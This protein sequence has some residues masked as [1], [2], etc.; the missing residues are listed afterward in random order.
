MAHAQW[1]EP[2]LSLVVRSAG[3]PLQ[4]VAPIQAIARRLDPEIPVA[5]VRSMEDA[6][7]QSM[8]SE[9]LRT[10]IFTGFASLALLLAAVGI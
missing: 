7:G 6:L 10:A 5:E 3:D 2:A 9:R 8:V 1:G 4:L